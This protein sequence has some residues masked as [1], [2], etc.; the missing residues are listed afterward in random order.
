MWREEEEV[1]GMGDKRRHVRVII[2]HYISGKN[3]ERTKY[4]LK[5]VKVYCATNLTVYIE[6]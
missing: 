4:N 6:L 5:S 1:V 2:I 3:W